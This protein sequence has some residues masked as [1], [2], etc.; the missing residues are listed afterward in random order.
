[1]PDLLDQQ[2][3][4]QRVIQWADAMHPHLFQSFYEN[5]EF[6]QDDDEAKLM[7]ECHLH[8]VNDIDLQ[9]TTT[10]LEIEMLRTEMEGR[11]IIGD[12]TTDE[13]HQRLYDTQDKK[14][15]LL[16]AK[17]RHISS[18]NAYWYFMQ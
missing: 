15:K 13:L 14:R 17:R 7:R 2:E 18:S 16:F 11:Q 1:M 12:L 5:L 10:D 6:P 8:A 4:R 3:A 9:I